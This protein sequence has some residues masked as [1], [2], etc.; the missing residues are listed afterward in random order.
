MRSLVWGISVGLTFIVGSA[1]AIVGGIVWATGGHAAGLIGGGAVGLLLSS[2]T[3]WQYLDEAYF[4]HRVV[5]HAVRYEPGD[6]WLLVRR[7]FPTR[8]LGLRTRASIDGRKPDGERRY[9][10]WIAVTDAIDKPRRFGPFHRRPKQGKVDALI[11]WINRQIDEI[12]REYGADDSP[13]E[14]PTAR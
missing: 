2:W 6:G 8:Y 13:N 9:I 11:K 14:K 7:C 1:A 4:A 5:R 3:T 10:Q 12:E